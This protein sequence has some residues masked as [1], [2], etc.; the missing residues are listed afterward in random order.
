MFR[1][2]SQTLDSHRR[3][4]KK[5]DLKDILFNLINEKRVFFRVRGDVMTLF[6]TFDPADYNG[7]Y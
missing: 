3:V 2:P 5:E 1:K 4:F 7:G 6:Y